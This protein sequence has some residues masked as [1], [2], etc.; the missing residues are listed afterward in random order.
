MRKKTTNGIQFVIKNIRRSV[1]KNSE[2]KI[3]L[4]K[5]INKLVN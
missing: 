5:K 1:H 4:W 2:I 3:I